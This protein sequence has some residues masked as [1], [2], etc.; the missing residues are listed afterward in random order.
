MDNQVIGDYYATEK[1]DKRSLET[2]PVIDDDKNIVVVNDIVFH[3]DEEKP[4]PKEQ[5]GERAG[6]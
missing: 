3:M 1:N 6:C 4:A 5:V 2:F